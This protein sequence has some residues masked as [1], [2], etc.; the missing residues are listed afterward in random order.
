MCHIIL[1]LKSYF[2]KKRKPQTIPV[3]EGA[4]VHIKYVFCNNCHATFKQF[5]C[6]HLSSYF[7]TASGQ[8][9]QLLSE[10]ETEKHNFYRTLNAILQ[11]KACE[12]YNLGNKCEVC[13]FIYVYPNQPKLQYLE[14]FCFINVSYRW[15]FL[16]GVTGKLISITF[17]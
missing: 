10:K 11:I 8:E 1:S 13:L 14:P 4:F 6:R 5:F 12:I 15:Q 16:I 2:S 7:S 17:R 3:N 9:K